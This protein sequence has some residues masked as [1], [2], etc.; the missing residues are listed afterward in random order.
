MASDPAAQQLSEHVAVVSGSAPGDVARSLEALAALWPR[1]ARAERQR[2]AA[3]TAR[4]LALLLDIR[5]PLPPREALLAR[6]LLARCLAWA[7]SRPA[8]AQAV[9]ALGLEQTVLGALVHMVMTS[10]DV[11]TA[12]G[13]AAALCRACAGD[14]GVGAALAAVAQKA[15]GLCDVASALV[16]SRDA[17]EARAGVDLWHA[18][19]EA[20][21][22]P[23]AIAHWQ[24]RVL[25]ERGL[26]ALAQQMAP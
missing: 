23:E 26:R 17:R 15:T 4:P 19:R 2:L 14:E 24:K 21:D 18:C 9:R 8:A 22:S 1:L 6:P 10:D 7:P 3:T 20:M 5:A 11:V 16:A 13:A 25:A 12:A